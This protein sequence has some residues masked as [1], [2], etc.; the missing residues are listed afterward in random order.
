VTTP[1]AE[2]VGDPVAHSK[3]PLIH[4]FW[5]KRLGI[6]GD[7]RCTRVTAS[8]LPS[9]LAARRRDP[10]WR[11]CNVTMPL[12]ELAL[13]AVDT[14]SSAAAG[15]GAAN[16]II[17]GE[18]GL[19][20]ANTDVAGVIGAL[21]HLLSREV[22]AIIGGG[23]AARAAV[24]ALGRHSLHDVRII[25]RDPDRARRKLG[26][27]SGDLRFFAVEDARRG[28]DCAERIIQASAAG[29]A[30]NPPLPQAVLDALADAHPD[31]FCLEMVY[32]P[33]LTPFVRRARELGYG[34]NDGI[35][36]LI[37]QAE[38]AFRLLF[39]APAPRRC[40]AELRELLRA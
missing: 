17:R 3:S 38:E 12:K 19:V 4:K 10:H 31:A 23:G 7:Y 33:P 6:E 37:A 22:A 39:G 21:P 29:M 13:A 18:A 27:I 14:C 35:A 16:C 2:V 24:Y 30:G 5:L 32:D 36:M 25:A 8:E 40:D 26:S 9:Y 1:Y 20:G 34:W 15:A 28:M 11:G